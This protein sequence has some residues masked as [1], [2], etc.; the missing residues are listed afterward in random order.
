MQMI[1]TSWLL[2]PMK[3]IV[4]EFVQSFTNLLEPLPSMSLAFNAL[5]GGDVDTFC[6]VASMSEIYEHHARRKTMS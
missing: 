2:L 5:M 1:R 3:T 6:P 4:S